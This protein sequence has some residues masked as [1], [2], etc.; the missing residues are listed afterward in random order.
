MATFISLTSR[1]V[2]YYLSELVS[3]GYVKRTGS[4]KK[5]KRIVINKGSERND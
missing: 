2:R 1:M 3:N 5:G 4:N